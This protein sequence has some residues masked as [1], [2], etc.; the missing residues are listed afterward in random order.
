MADMRRLAHLYAN[1]KG[2]C[3]EAQKQSTSSADI[4]SH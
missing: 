2:K 3:D 1:F 4:D